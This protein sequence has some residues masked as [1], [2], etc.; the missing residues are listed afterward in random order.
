MIPIQESVHGS[1]ALAILMKETWI[2]QSGLGSISLICTCRPGCCSDYYP[3]ICSWCCSSC[4]TH[5][6]DLATP[7]LLCGQFSFFALSVMGA[8]VIT[9]QESVPGALPPVVPMTETWLYHSL[10]NILPWHLL[11]WCSIGHYIRICTMT[12]ASWFY[13]SGL[14]KF[15]LPTLAFHNC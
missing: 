12:E 15:T 7:I 9:I 10:V 6:R 1:V 4:G 3:R 2:Q 13:Q 8:A 14:L 5:D 11:T